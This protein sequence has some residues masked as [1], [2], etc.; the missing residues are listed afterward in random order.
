[1]RVKELQ[2][3]MHSQDVDSVGWRSAAMENKK[4]ETE[5]TKGKDQR[6]K[7]LLSTAKE[8]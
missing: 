3:T 6:K 5:I 4:K 1:M 7:E 8:E 2:P